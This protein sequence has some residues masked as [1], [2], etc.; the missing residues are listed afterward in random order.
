MRVDFKM[1]YINDWIDDLGRHRYRFRRKGFPGVE[2]PVDS[3]PNSL[4]FQAAYH[5]ALRGE[6][7]SAAIATVTARGGSGSVGDAVRQY[8][9]STTF[10]DDYS[11]STKSLRRSILKSFLKPGV[12]NLPLARMDRRYIERWLETA[13]TRGVKRTWLLAAKPFTKWATEC[14]HLIEQDPCEGIKVK[15]KETDGH[16]TWTDEHIEKFR[17]RHPVSTK[18]RLALELMLHLATRRGDGI[19]LGRQH[20]KDGWVIYTQEK[21]RGRKPV[22]VETPLPEPVVAA[23]KACPSPPEALTFLTNEWGRPFSKKAFGTWF[24]KR[25]DEAGL[26]ESCVPHGLRKAGCR[27]MGDSSCTPHDIMAVS[28]HRTLKEVMRYTEAYNRKQAAARAQAKVAA[29][30]DN[31][32]PLTVAAKR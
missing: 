3:D 18:A 20:V 28:G 21:N 27:I 1:K 32:V 29:P 31:V 30:K 5:A 9:D 12:G 10:N 19:S 11:P 8:L 15:V 7:T 13:P 4:E 6:T 16:P 26:P 14:V 25:C 22:L 24:R 17:A 23:I 2:L